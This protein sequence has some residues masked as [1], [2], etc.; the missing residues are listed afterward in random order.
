MQGAVPNM[1]H[2]YHSA[3]DLNAVTTAVH[4]RHNCVTG[5]QDKGGTHRGRQAPPRPQAQ[6]GPAGPAF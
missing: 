4:S 1:Y 3:I 5:E 2:L 6:D